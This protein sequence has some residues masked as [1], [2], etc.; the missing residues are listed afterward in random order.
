MNHPSAQFKKCPYIY[1]NCALINVCVLIRMYFHLGT[2][3][4]SK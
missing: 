4:K 2:S 1:R 3:I